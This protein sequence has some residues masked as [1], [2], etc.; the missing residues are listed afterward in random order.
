MK[1]YQKLQ[2]LKS[3]V[4]GE[5]LSLIGLIKNLDAN[6][7]IAIETLRARYENKRVLMSNHLNRLSSSPSVSSDSLSK[8]RQMR[9]TLNV[10]LKSLSSLDCDT[11]SWGPLLI[12][13]MV[14]KFSVGL[15][16]EWKKSLAGST[17]YPTY[18]QFTTFLTN[19][20]HILENLDFHKEITKDENANTSAKRSKVT[21]NVTQVEQPKCVCCHDFHLLF[22]CPKFNKMNVSERKRVRV[23]NKLC[24]I[25]LQSDHKLS[26]CLSKYVCKKC[27]KKHHTLLHY[28]TKVDKSTKESKLSKTAQQN[29]RLTN[30]VA[31]TPSIQ[32]P[33]TT[34]ISIPKD[35][36]VMIDT[37]LV[38]V[39]SPDGKVV[40]VRAILDSASQHLFITESLVQT[41]RL[42]KQRVDLLVDGLGGVRTG[43]PKF[44]AECNFRS[45]YTD[46]YTFNINAYILQAITSYKPKKF[47]PRNYEELRHLILA[48]PEPAKIIKI[49][50]LLGADIK[51]RL[52]QSG[53]IQ[54]KDTNLTAKSTI[55]GWVVSGPLGKPAHKTITVH[56][57][58]V[59]IDTLLQSFWQID[60][61]ITKST[62][63]PEDERC[64][65]IF[66]QTTTRDS[67][68]RYIVKLLFLSDE[69]AE[70]LGDSRNIAFASWTRV[71]ER[72]DKDSDV[73][74]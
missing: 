25:C 61:L 74:R 26:N 40:T 53:V 9:D 46:E 64:E 33:N 41:L 14:Q 27:S 49:E 16:K 18:D 59:S 28:D 10:V 48:D 37:A 2:H 38:R 30:P 24:V 34:L 4:Q 32:P 43:T 51:G 57:A 67:S 72:L 13:Q 66:E 54:I 3:L 5:A 52:L 47:N 69:E 65:K 1:P 29:P 8:M 17:E 15:R 35:E 11:R 12:H 20:I 71:E 39:F 36:D 21:L 22:R 7:P 44:L 6:Y 56:H 23:A 19:Q 42:P 63:T 45:V 70:K 50:L 55:M 68:G 58:S 73:R 60:D 62:M 31:Q